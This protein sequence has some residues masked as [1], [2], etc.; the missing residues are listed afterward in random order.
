MTNDTFRKLLPISGILSALL[1][2]GGIFGAPSA[3]QVAS[4]NH[5]EVIAFYQD[6]ASAISLT[7]IVFG[8]LAVFFLVPLITELRAVLRSGE[9]GE[10]IY[11]TLALIGG[12]IL[13]VGTSVMALSGAVVASAADAGLSDDTVLSAAIV[14]DYTWMP[15]VVGAA[16][17]LWSVGLGGLRT[18]TLPKWLSWVSIVLGALCLTGFGGIAVFMVMPL[19]LLA[20]SVILLRKQT[21]PATAPIATPATA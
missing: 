21:A 10:A 15:W 1:L 13:A 12:T 11:S 7:N 14:A 6:H 2:A 16:V 3:P 20:T 19:W 9:A 5:A 8:L 17:F 4:D 18:A